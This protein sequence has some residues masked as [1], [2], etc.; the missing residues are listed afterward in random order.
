MSL[1]VDNFYLQEERNQSIKK[2]KE[3][4]KEI[5]APSKKK[6]DT[7]S[8]LKNITNIRANRNHAQSSK[9]KLDYHVKKNGV[10]PSKTPIAKTKTPISKEQAHL[11][12]VPSDPLVATIDFNKLL[13]DVSPVKSREQNSKKLNELGNLKVKPKLEIKHKYNKS[14][15]LALKE[16]SICWVPPEV[17][18]IEIIADYLASFDIDEKKRAE[19]PIIPKVEP[20]KVYKL[21][22]ILDSDDDEEEDV[23]EIFKD[24]VICDNSSSSEQISQE[25]DSEVMAGVFSESDEKRLEARQKQIDIGKNT[26]GYQ[27]YVSIIPKDT[28]K[29]GQPLTPNKHQVCSKRSWDGQVRKWRRMIHRFDPK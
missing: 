21:E 28:R 29:R 24:L 14:E 9:K 23:Q 27:H 20:P 13:I 19:V 7:R 1:L 16:K 26:P 18:P 12:P 11:T 5:P 22:I 15:M 25:H 17:S 10:S 4:E 3:K 6:K 8:S 2:E